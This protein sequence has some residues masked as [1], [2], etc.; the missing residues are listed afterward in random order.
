[1]VLCVGFTVV[2]PFGATLPTP[3]VMVTVGRAAGRPA[4]GRRVAG[5]DVERAGLEA[6]DLRVAGGGRAHSDGQR[7]G[8]RSRGAGRGQGVSG[9]GRG[10]TETEPVCGFTEP[11]AG[12]IVADVAFL[13]VQL[14]VV[15]WPG[16]T[17]A[18]LAVK[19]VICAWDGARGAHRGG[20]RARQA[21][22]VFVTS[23]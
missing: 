15:A 20:G 14:S 11:T 7:L 3:G 5:L 17:L 9:G 16:V 6:N 19:E 18:G 22:G 13:M 4:Q 10:E 1:M 8:N 12:A 21:V 23:G 2:L